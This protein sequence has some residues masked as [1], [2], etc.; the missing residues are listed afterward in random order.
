MEELIRHI[1]EA[2]KKANQ[3][4][5]KK[6]QEVK[7]VQNEIKAKQALIKEKYQTESKME[8]DA[9]VK[10]LDMELKEVEKQDALAYEAAL[11][12][13]KDMYDTHKDEWIKKI[14]D[15]CMQ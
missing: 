8:I 11:K 3:K 10:A 2:D 14:V 9:K 12:K 4:L 1:I 15:H 7:N 6:Q 13:V 5:V